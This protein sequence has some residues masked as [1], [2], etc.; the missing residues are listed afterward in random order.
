MELSIAV[1]RTY[2]QSYVRARSASKTLCHQD[3]RSI[4]STQTETTG[5]SYSTCEVVHT[6]T[7]GVYM[8]CKTMVTM[9]ARRGPF[10]GLQL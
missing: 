5:H 3:H 9:E 6:A 8:M 10:S 7:K 1:C 4:N 2:K